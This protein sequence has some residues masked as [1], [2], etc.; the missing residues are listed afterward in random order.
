MIIL[1][2][3]KAAI[4]C[5]RVTRLP[6]HFAALAFLFVLFVA[7]AMTP[8]STAHAVETNIADPLATIKARGRHD[9]CV[10]PRAVPIV[11]AMAA[12]VLLDAHLMDKSCHL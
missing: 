2:L 4:A 9:P 8:L 6:Q 11:E 3:A 12:M 5:F 1:V 10:L 7:P